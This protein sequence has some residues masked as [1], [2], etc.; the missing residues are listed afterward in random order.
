MLE[1]IDKEKKRWDILLFL[2]EVKETRN[3][4]LTSKIFNGTSFRRKSVPN[5]APLKFFP[6]DYDD[7]LFALAFDFR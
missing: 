3:N 6:T 2:I 1:I 7:N 4:I 5:A